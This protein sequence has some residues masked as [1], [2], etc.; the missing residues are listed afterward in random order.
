[1]LCQTVNVAFQLAV[2]ELKNSKMKKNG[3]AFTAVSQKRDAVKGILYRRQIHR[4]DLKPLHVLGYVREVLSATAGSGRTRTLTRID[5][6][7]CF[8]Q[9]GPVWGGVP[10]A[11]GR[12]GSSGR[13]R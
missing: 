1:M 5:S 12:Q 3:N 11:A 4:R 2:E 6:W 9:D 8:L 7:P 10:G 13:R